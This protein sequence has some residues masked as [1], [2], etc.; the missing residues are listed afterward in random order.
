MCREAFYGNS[1]QQNA[2]LQANIYERNKKKHN[3]FFLGGKGYKN[4]SP[5]E[6]RKI[7]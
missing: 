6:Q 7:K 1:E 2:K 4:E 3:S 5:E